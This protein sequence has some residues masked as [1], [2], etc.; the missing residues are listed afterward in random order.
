MFLHVPHG[1]RTQEIPHDGPTRLHIAEHEGKSATVK[2]RC[3]AQGA[4]V[5]SRAE[6][7]VRSSEICHC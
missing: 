2:Y 6:V 3:C 1:K 7:K 5:C 4:W